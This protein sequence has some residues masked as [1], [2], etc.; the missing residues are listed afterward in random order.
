MV[1]T[2]HVVRTCHATWGVTGWWLSEVLFQVILW[3]YYSVKK[4]LLC[5]LCC[6]QSTW[7]FTYSVSIIPLLLL[8]RHLQYLQPYIRCME[9]IQRQ[10]PNHLERFPSFDRWDSIVLY[11]SEAV[12]L[13]MCNCLYKKIVKFTVFVLLLSRLIKFNNYSGTVSIIV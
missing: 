11:S 2:T 8:F 9:A 3:Y 10:T 1:K 5:W 7:P 13:W 6:Y 12:G 4:P